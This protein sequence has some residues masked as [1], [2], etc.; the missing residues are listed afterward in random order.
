MN[1]SSKRLL[2]ILVFTAI[3][4]ANAYDIL[5]ITQTIYILPVIWLSMRLQK[6][7]AST[8]GLGKPA[9]WKST[10]LFGLLF[11]IGLELFAIYVTTPLFSSWTGNPPDVSAL[12]DIEGNLPALLFFILLS[13]LLGAFG[14]EICFRGFLMHRLSG[15]MNFSRT[16]WI[17]ALIVSSV[18]FGWGHTEQGVSGWIQEG[19]SGL[20]LGLLFLGFG[21][22]L[23]VPIIAHG[24]SNTLAFVLIYFGMYPGM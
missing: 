17:I 20:W 9:H 16:G 12:S 4:V 2:D 18:L 23:Y 21:K 24:T 19:L 7:P 6:E 5:P 14:E 22:N 15:L 1:A 10:V 8:I 13:W 3:V 11:G